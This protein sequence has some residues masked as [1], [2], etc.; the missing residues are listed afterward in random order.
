MISV[1]F[2]EVIRF[3]RSS[4]ACKESCFSIG[5][6]YYL[7]YHNSEC[8]CGHVFNVS[9]SDSGLT[10]LNGA[11]ENHCFCTLAM[12][13]GQSVCNM[14]FIHGAISSQP[15][16]TLSSLRPHST[17]ENVAFTIHTDINITAY[18][19]DFGDFMSSTI[20]SDI[21]TV[22]YNYGIPGSYSVKV[23]LVNGNGSYS[24]NVPV[25]IQTPVQ[26]V[27]LHVPEYADVE[28][29][30]DLRAVVSTGSG[31]EISWLRQIRKDTSESGAYLS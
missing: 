18:E 14:F 1:K 24:I 22:T 20:T 11:A 4:L 15:T 16:V 6:E 7:F 5:L 10:M 30:L 12:L 21:S 13:T 9:N 26:D 2:N 3:Q 25:V 8:F 28:K 23:S 29:D 17:L 31:V 27:S 19:W